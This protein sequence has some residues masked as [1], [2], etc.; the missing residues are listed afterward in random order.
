MEAHSREIRYYQTKTG[1]VP[2][3][4]FLKRLKEAKIRA[5]I[6]LRVARAATGNF[7]DHSSVGNGLFELR[8]HLGPGFR[9]YYGLDGDTFV[10][11]ATAGEKKTQPKD[12]KSAKV[13][14][15]DYLKRKS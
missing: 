7:G 6:D 1:K 10:V 12:I 9:V 3:W 4:D 8:L 11:V 15:E 2:Y 5:A 13:F 14:W